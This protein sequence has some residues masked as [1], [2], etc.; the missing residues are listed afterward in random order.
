MGGM[1]ARLARFN[2]FILRGEKRDDKRFMEFEEARHLRPG[3][4]PVRNSSP[5]IA[6][7]ET[8]RGI[9]S[10]LKTIKECPVA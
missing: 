7:L 1:T 9:K 5:A 4:N 3:R 6:G 10:P 8:E 2:D